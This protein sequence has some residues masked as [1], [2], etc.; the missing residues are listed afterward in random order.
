[1]LTL[2]AI[3]FGSGWFP[4][5]SKRQGR[6][7]Y[8]TVALGL[9]DRFDAEGAWAAGDLREMGAQELARTLGQDL[10]VPEVSELMDLYARAL[11]DLGAFLLDRHGG[12]FG[13]PVEAAGRSAARL[14]EALTA[15]PLYRDVARYG[16]A[17]VPFLKRAQITVADLRLAFAGSGPGRFDDIDDL[18]LF[19]DNL[20]PH[21]LRLEGVLVYDAELLARIEAG[22]LLSPGSPEEVEIRAC[23]L[24]AVERMAAVA[25]DAARAVPPWRLDEWLWT[26]G[27]QPE[28]KAVPRHR[29]RSAFY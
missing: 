29:T 2:D 18:T 25:R 6:S 15:M 24:H 12:R 4:H 21:V 8:F 13:G 5:L 27:Q 26:L 7:G 14:V 17:D 1:V 19:A 22:R 9:S 16:R 10:S 3:N 20:V 28:R 23:A 11:R